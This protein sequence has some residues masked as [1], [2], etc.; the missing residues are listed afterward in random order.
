[1][2]RFLK[3]VGNGRKTARDLTTVEA[4]EAFEVALGQKALHPLGRSAQVLDR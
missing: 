2:Q 3:I 1:M 4:E